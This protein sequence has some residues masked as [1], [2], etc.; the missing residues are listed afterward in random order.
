MVF[1]VVGQDLF[2]VHFPGTVELIAGAVDFLYKALRIVDIL[3]FPLIVV[4]DES[5]QT[6]QF[7]VGI[8]ESKL[9]LPFII[10]V[11]NGN[12]CTVGML[13][14]IEKD[15]H[16]VAYVHRDAIQFHG[17]NI[18]VAVHFFHQFQALFPKSLF[19][20]FPDRLRRGRNDAAH[21]GCK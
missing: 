13:I 14:V 16:V 20:F 4:I 12:P 2:L 7:V 21:Q 8:F 15:S 19:G 9:H 6:V 18:L 3:I 17:V 5:G 10:E 1:S 11:K